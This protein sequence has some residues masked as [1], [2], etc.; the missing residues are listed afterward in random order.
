[1]RFPR[2]LQL[3]VRLWRHEDC[4]HVT[5]RRRW[6]CALGHCHE[7]GPAAVCQSAAIRYYSSQ[8]ERWQIFVCLSLFCDLC[9][10]FVSAAVPTVTNII[11]CSNTSS[12]TKIQECLRHGGNT[13]TL[14][15]SNFGQANAAVLIGV[16]LASNVVQDPA[17]PHR[18]L[19]FT[20]PLGTGIDR[21]VLFYSVLHRFVRLILFVPSCSPVLLLQGG[22][23]ISQ[24]DVRLSY[25]ECQPGE[26]VVG[27]DCQ[28]CPN[29][30]FSA[31]TSAQACSPCL[32]GTFAESPIGA[33]RCVNCPPG[34]ASGSRQF[35][36]TSCTTAAPLNQLSHGSFCFALC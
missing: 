23:G 6:C 17:T 34:S 20:T 30:T 16:A 21:C 36:C 31:Q 11:G 14:L 22:G 8:P 28:L 13:V 15:G 3:C 18:K 7:C 25:A 29:G 27:L 1:M 5:G 26:F 32:S 9:V 35:A 33:S 10:T 2:R 12:V 4:V 19:T 24:S